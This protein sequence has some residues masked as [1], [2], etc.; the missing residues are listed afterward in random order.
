MLQV[1]QHQKSGE[2]QVVELPM[3]QCHKN[4]ILVATQCSLISAGTEKASVSSTKLPLIERARRQPDQVKLV[5]DFIKKEG[6]IKTL[7]RVKS[8]LDSY[9]TLGYS[10]SGVVVDSDCDEFKPGDRVACGG[11][12]FAVHA[13]MISVPKNLAVHIPEDVDFESAAFTTVGAIAMQG[14]RQAGPEIGETVA[15]I[16]LGLIG[17]ITVQLLKAAGCRVVGMDIDERLFPLAKDAGC[18]L[19]LNSDFGSIN[20]CL[21]FSRGLGCD[22]VIITA[23][24]QSNAPLELGLKI[25]R[26]KGKVVIVGAVS[27]NVPRSPFYEKEIDLKIA[28]SYGPGRYDPHYEINGNDYPPA[29]VRWTERRNMQA[30]IDLISLGKLDFSKIITHKFNIEEIARAYDLISGKGTDFYLGILVKYPQRADAERIFIEM[31]IRRDAV[32]ELKLGFIGAGQFAQSNLLPHLKKQGIDFI[33]VTTATPSNA[34]TVARQFDF[35]FSSTDSSSMINRDDI[36]LVFIATKHDSHAKYVIESLK[37]GKNV[38]VE[39]PLALNRTEISEIETALNIG[40]GQIMTGF[41]RRFSAV[42]NRINDF[43]KGRTAPLQMMYRVNAGFIPKEHW[44]NSPENGGRIIGEVCHFIDCMVFLTKSLPIKVYANAISSDSLNS[45]NHSNLMI[46]IT[47]SDGSIGSVIYTADAGKDMPKEYFEAFSE[48]KS[49][50]MDNFK[51]L[52]YYQ[53]GSS[54][55]LKFDGSKGHEQEI[56]AF[57]N[58]LRKGVPLPIS[59]NEQKYITL[60]TIAAEESLLTGNPVIIG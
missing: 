5:L 25:C 20:S 13:E 42:F 48:Q 59:F 40:K 39:K 12:G 44:I 41:N 35:K 46:N 2:I 1:L 3:P 11:A 26:K 55:T 43:F 28:C 29:Y 56:V 57:I 8:K 14:I 52:N 36:N 9:K 37:L 54:S 50:S 38:F 51:T 58:S 6:L 17:L 34:L 33:G 60:A 4:G 24:T 10:A 23:A 7:N 32:S 45:V 18:D 19:V 49:I 22:S 16:G 47:F 30:F 53:S 15:V 21:A 31:P 27:M